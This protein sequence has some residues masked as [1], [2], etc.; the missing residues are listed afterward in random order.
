MQFEVLK[1][2]KASQAER[3]GGAIQRAAVNHQDA[4]GFFRFGHQVFDAATNPGETGH[5]RH[6]FTRKPARDMIGQ[7]AGVRTTGAGI[8]HRGRL[9]W[10]DILFFKFVAHKI[11][12]HYAIKLPRLRQ[13]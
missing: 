10:R 6:A 9:W 11:I 5:L 7:F 13:E 8:D 1:I 12:C 2:L 4:F 3:V